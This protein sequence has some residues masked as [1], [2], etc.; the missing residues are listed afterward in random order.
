[1]KQETRRVLF[2]NGDIWKNVETDKL[3]FMTN[4][5]HLHLYQFQVQVTAWCV[6]IMILCNGVIN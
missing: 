4:I 2:S 1:M 5:E 3:W 6:N